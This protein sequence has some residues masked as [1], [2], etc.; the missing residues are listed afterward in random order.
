M[1]VI[2]KLKQLTLYDKDIL[3]SHGDL[4]EEIYFIFTGSILIYT[5][6][7]DIIDMRNLVK[8]DGAFNVPI[9]VYSSGS[10][11]GDSDA[12]MGINNY[13]TVTATSQGESKLYSIKFS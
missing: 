1:S 9:T 13:R 2:P 4:A 6:L 11:F 5:D 8:S 7:S 12:M 3:F 10:I